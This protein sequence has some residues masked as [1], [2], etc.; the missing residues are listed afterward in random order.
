MTPSPERTQAEMVHR[1]PKATVVDRIA[2]MCARAQ[3]RRVVHVGFV[4]T[5]YRELSAESGTWLH[6][7]LSRYARSLV[8]IDLD[9]A[10][11]EDA[12]RQGYEAHVADCRNPEAI[13]ALGLEPA[14]LVVAGEIIEHLD[15]PGSFLDGLHPLVT[16]GG[17]LLLSTP[18]AYGL[19]NVFASLAGFEVNHPDH[20]TMFSWQTLT[21]LLA[22]HGWR[23]VG[24]K[25]FVFQVK[26]STG[27]SSR[28]RTFEAGARAI[29]ALERTLGRL[30]APFAADGLIILARPTPRS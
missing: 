28:Q 6:E 20:V 10:G 18:N 13:E 7:H 24:A 19:G 11:V 17:T 30:G 21:N 23:A 12:R 27:A 16:P 14:E 1:L 2:Y 26:P 8:G 3:G 4:D 9:V 29:I 22:R 25:T 5:G 15:D